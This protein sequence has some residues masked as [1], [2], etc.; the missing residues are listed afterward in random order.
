MEFAEEPK[1]VNT[2]RKSELYIPIYVANDRLYK[3]LENGKYRS[4]VL[5]TKRPEY[6]HYFLQDKN[7]KKLTI[8][9][10]KLDLLTWTEPDYEV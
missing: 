3:R 4:L 1:K 9:A 8:N 5:Q 10:H 6:N 2:L 7:K